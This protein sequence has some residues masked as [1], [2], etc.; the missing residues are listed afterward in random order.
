LVRAMSDI[1]SFVA[2]HRRQVKSISIEEKVKQLPWYK[3]PIERGAF[4]SRKAKDGKYYV[5]HEEW[6][7][8]IWIGPYK[9]MKDCD[10]I[11]NSYVEKSSVKPLD[12]ITP[13]REIHSVYVDDVD[14]FF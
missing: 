12:R 4:T 1:S 10:D 8:T 9:S 6:A 2:K 3:R 14:K 7:E 11:I 13:D 5:R